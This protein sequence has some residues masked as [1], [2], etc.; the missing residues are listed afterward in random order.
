MEEGKCHIE[1]GKRVYC[2]AF[3]AMI[4]NAVNIENVTYSE[5]RDIKMREATATFNRCPFCMEWIGEGM[6]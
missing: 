5:D 3:K 1:N 2:D 6:K 4:E